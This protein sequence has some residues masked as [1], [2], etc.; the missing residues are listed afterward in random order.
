M[1]KATVEQTRMGTELLEQRE[2][3]DAADMVD[4]M[5][6]ALNDPAFFKP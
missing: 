2:D 6:K 3:H 4:T 1:S 5:I